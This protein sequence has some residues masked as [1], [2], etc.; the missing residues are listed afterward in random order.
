MQ[1][2]VRLG[3]S[4]RMVLPA[5]YRKALGLR[6]G[7]EIVVQLEGDGLRLSSLRA[8]IRHSQA[9]VARYVATDR[10]LVDDLIAE[11]RSEPT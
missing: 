4:G 1:A 10:S 2:R 7:D 8:A 11:R 3:K 6:P 9:I 5:A